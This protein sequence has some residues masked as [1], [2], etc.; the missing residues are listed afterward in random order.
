MRRYLVFLLVVLAL[1]NLVLALYAPTSLF[2]ATPQAMKVQGALTDR[3]SGTPVP[4]NGTFSMTFGLF[5]APFGGALL[6]TIGPMPVDAIQGRFSV[7]LPLGAPQFQGP[8]RYL[9]IAVAGEVL[10]PRLHLVSTP[11]SFSAD[12]SSSAATAASADLALTVAP[13]SVNSAALAQGAVGPSALAIGAVGQAALATG[14]VSADKLGIPC[15]AGQVLVQSGSGWTCGSTGSGGTICS[16]GGFINCYH[17]PSGTLNVGVCR[18]G[19]SACNATGTAFEGCQG[20]VDP[21]SEIC[22]GKDNDCNPSTA[23]GAQ[24]PGFGL[25]CDGPDLD[26]CRNGTM[27]CSS[28][29]YACTGPSEAGP[30][31]QA[32]M[33]DGRG[34]DE[35]CNPATPDGYNDPRLQGPCDGNDTDHCAEGTWECVNAFPV[36]ND[37]TGSTID[38][39]NGVDDDCY[40]PTLDGSQDPQV[41]IP[42]DGPDADLCKEGVTV[43]QGG[44]I[45][46]ND[47]TGNTVEVCGD[48]IDNDC[49]GQI[50]EGC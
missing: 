50:D 46:C 39:C 17:G 25:A 36:C 49:D 38:L 34:L 29:T 41:G 23:D 24:E 19:T 1:S 44:A 27:T 20:E 22:D 45:A 7:E 18:A 14:S 43:C 48:N 6:A 9:Q 32:D 3:S 10:T 13:G 21:S 15:A 8:D 16:Q 42:C 47:T 33:C 35:D 4:A 40:T 2:A 30:I 26:L 12:K 11:F 37:Q 5:D 28:G 31:G